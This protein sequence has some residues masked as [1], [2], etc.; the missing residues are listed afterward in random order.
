MNDEAA[1]APA[2]KPR[3]GPFQWVVGTL[4]GLL[5]VA[6]LF[7]AVQQARRTA[8]LPDTVP[9]PA[10]T[11]QRLGGGTVSLDG[12]K[13]KVVLLD[14]WATWCPPCRHELP[15]LVRVA[16]EFEG[17]GVTLVAASRDEPE[18]AAVAVSYFVDQVLPALREHAVV[19]APDLMARQYHVDSLPTLYILDREGR[20]FDSAKGELTEAQLRRRVAKAVGK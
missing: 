6:M 10:F 12:L 18:T 3:A 9:A 15:S 4:V 7:Q 1:P 2:A 17:D 16:K 14:F 19:F 11:V 13:G 5:L 20:V 8:L